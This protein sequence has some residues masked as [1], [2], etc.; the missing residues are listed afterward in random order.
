MMDNL[1]GYLVLVLFLFPYFIYFFSKRAEKRNNK[2]KQKIDKIKDVH[3]VELSELKT[4]Y[5]NEIL[6]LKDEINNLNKINEQ[7]I[8]KQNSL[9]KEI[10]KLKDV[11]RQKDKFYESIKQRKDIN[12]ISSLYA[13]HLLIQYDLSSKILETKKHPAL[14]EAKRI[15]ELKNETSTYIEQYRQMLYKY[16]YLIKLFPELSNYIDD[17]ESLKE[18]EDLSNI[19]SLKT[20][21]DRVAYYLDKNEYEKYTTDERNQL[22][23]DR[24][25]NGPKTNWQIGRDYE[26][27]CGL[28]YENNGWQV[29]YTGMEKKLNDLGRDLI[30]KKDNTHLVIQCKYWSKEKLIH[31]KHITQIFGTA[32]EYELSLKNDNN[33]FPIKVIPVFITNIELSETARA[34]ARRLGVEFKEKYKIKDFP[35]I[36]CNINKNEYGEIT[37]IYH[38]PF[39]QQ[40]DKTK[41]NGNGQFYA[42]TVNEAVK[43][44][45]RRAFKYHG[46]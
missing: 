42:Y 11:I 30:A 34:F 38:L 19:N 15:K 43:K 31:E 2:I 24:Y 44:G 37:K 35:R 39:D 14:K 17:F 1:S 20:D 5:N 9:E 27:F 28:Q 46:F 21:F 36:K 26:L 18:L 6:E 22:A 40:Y 32:I 13:D 3:S 33:I 29:E 10:S 16:E 7:N 12:I 23:L 8:I 45:F 25:I 4:R 41:I